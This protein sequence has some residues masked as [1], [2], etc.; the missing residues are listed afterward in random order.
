MTMKHIAAVAVF[1]VLSACAMNAT[2]PG[3][4][5]IPT[6]QG[7]I[8]AGYAAVTALDQTAAT[9]QAAGKLSAADKANVIASSEAA[10]TGLDL[11]ETLATTD[12]TSA[13][14]KLTSVMTVLGALQVYLATKGH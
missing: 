10:L 1:S 11:A 6:I 2:A 3:G 7:G 9:L 8:A 4:A 13:S 14:A 5:A 12:A